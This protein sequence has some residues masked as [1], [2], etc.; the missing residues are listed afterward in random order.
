MSSP[1]SQ[2]VTSLLQAA[3]AREPG[4]F[5]RLVEATYRDMHGLAAGRLGPYP[6]SRLAADGLGATALA[7]ETFER[8]MAQRNMAQN[9]DQFFA[10]ATRLMRRVL[11]DHRRKVGAQRRGGNRGRQGLTDLPLAADAAES[12][13]AEMNSAM[14]T[15][16]LRLHRL[17]P[18]KAEVVTLHAVCGV[19]LERVAE[20]IGVSVPTVRRDWSFARVWLANAVTQEQAR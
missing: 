16:L 4:G 13:G 6:D 9:R 5:A 14:R 11:A 2:S 17:D 8:L 18:R 12:T 10:L 7:H 20:I 3:S 15:A 19:P 1:G